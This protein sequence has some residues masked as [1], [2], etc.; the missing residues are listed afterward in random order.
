MESSSELQTEKNIYEL[1]KITQDLL[2]PQLHYGKVRDAAIALKQL[3]SKAIDFDETS[4]SVREH[5]WTENGQAVATWTAAFCVDDF[6]RTRNF[7]LGIKAAIEKKSN[8]NPYEPVVVMYAGTGPFAT[9]L[10]PLTTIFTARQLQLFCIE[11]N[12]LSFQYLQKTIL[13]FNMRD[14]VIDA[15]QVDAVN[16]IIPDTIKPHI[17]LSET[18]KEGLLKEQQVS[19]VANLMSQCLSETILIPELIKVDACIAGKINDDPNDFVFLETLFALDANMARA[20]KKTPERVA[21]LSEGI[22]F[23]IPV[24][25]ADNYN[26]FFLNTQIKIFGENT[27]GYNESGITIPH[28]I[29]NIIKPATKPIQLLVHYELG[30]NPEYRFAEV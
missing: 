3:F 1:K 26:R 15:V 21:I 13:Q 27:L 22:L 17:V 8:E 23:T 9:L 20:I 11:M 25:P 29:K 6:M 14:Y 10:T 28:F 2:M 12:G 7:I 16:Y 4:S 18:M 30:S 24:L 5:I 19:I